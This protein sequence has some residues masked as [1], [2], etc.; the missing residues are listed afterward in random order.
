MRDLSE[1]NIFSNG[2]YRSGSTLIYNLLWHI[3]R[4]KHF[5]VKEVYKLHYGQWLNKTNLMEDISFCTIRDVRDSAASMLRKT[6]VH[7]SEL[8]KKK[9]V[10]IDEFILRNIKHGNKI[11][12]HKEEGAEIYFLR[13]EVDILKPSNAARSI[14]DV[15]EVELS[16]KEANEIDN[17]FSIESQKKI[18]DKLIENKSCGTTQYWP[19]HIG[20][21]R[22]SYKD[23]FSYNDL[24]EDTLEVLEQWLNE[25]N[26]KR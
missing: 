8:K 19:N 3:L 22:T 10:T 4:K 16:D 2:V 5:T 25:N 11:K 12:K 14:C 1:K 17:L 13:Y 24:K 15:F 6:N 20:D 23:Y 7:F 18:V 9:N 26:Y 21:G